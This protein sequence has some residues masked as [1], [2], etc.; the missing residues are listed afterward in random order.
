MERGT[1]RWLLLAGLVWAAAVGVSRWKKA[2]APPAPPA[3]PSW[4]RPI[5]E[6]NVAQRTRFEQ[7]RAA[8]VRAEQARGGGAWP[9]ELAPGF[10]RRQQ[11]L[12][13]NYV[14]EA[15][16]LRWLVLF[17]EPDPRLP[18]ERAPLD[19][20]HHELPDGTPI[21]VTVWTQPTSEPPPEQVTAFPAAEG[22]V[23]RVRR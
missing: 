22:W 5:S 2:A 1:L 18:L 4:Q 20:E 19:D 16:G 10:R 7:L 14:G 21:H 9:D 6:L 12:H 23:E 13:V 17:I 11:R 8:I 3:A 15:E